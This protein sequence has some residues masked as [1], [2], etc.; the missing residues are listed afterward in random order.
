[1]YAWKCWH[2]SRDRVILYA[3]ASLAIGLMFGGVAL[4]QY[5]AMTSWGNTHVERW[6]W[7]PLWWYWVLDMIAASLLPAAVWVALSLGAASVGREYRSGAMPFLLTRPASRKAFVWTDWSLGLAQMTVILA[8]MLVGVASVLSGIS[9]DYVWLCFPPLL[10]CVV[11]GAALYGLT[12]FTTTLAGSSMKGLSASAAVILFYELLPGALKE[13]WHVSGPLGFR[14]WSL[15]LWDW[16]PG[17]T[18]PF[19]LYGWPILMWLLIALA[20]PLLSQI[21]L[22]WREA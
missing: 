21:V 12:H 22:E 9:R 13:W 5:H 7:D 4:G 19:T 15:N 10:G 2:D 11:L 3:A 1:M 17:K 18:D 6:Y 14:D 20:F 16:H 8:M